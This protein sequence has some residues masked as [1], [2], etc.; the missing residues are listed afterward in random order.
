MMLFNCFR[1]LFSSF[2]LKTNYFIKPW[3]NTVT[4]GYN[5]LW[6]F[7][8]SAEQEHAT[9]PSTPKKGGQK[10]ASQEKPIRNNRN[11]HLSTRNTVVP[12]KL[13]SRMGIDRHFYKK[14]DPSPKELRSLYRSGIV[15]C[16]EKASDKTMSLPIAAD[17][18]TDYF[19]WCNFTRN[20]DLKTPKPVY[21]VSFYSF[22]YKKEA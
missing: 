11:I 6:A 8:T 22:F 16:M 18:S 3:K 4:L 1:S 13:L 5:R 10:W 9:H 19:Q 2:E 14:A 17:I 20:L 15:V 12:Q 21:N 7:L